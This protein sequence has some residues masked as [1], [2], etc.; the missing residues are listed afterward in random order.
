MELMDAIRNHPF[1][2]MHYLLTHGG[3]LKEK[4]DGK[5]AL[6]EAVEH[7]KKYLV[8]LF[9]TR[10]ADVDVCDENGNSPLH[11][12]CKNENS[13]ITNILLK[14]NA[15]IEKKNKYGH[16]P[17]HI[18]SYR[19]SYDLIDLLLDKGADLNCKDNHGHTPLHIATL[20]NWPS[21]KKLID[22]GANLDAMD[23]YKCTPKHYVF[24][25]ENF[26]LNED[27]KKYFANDF[28]KFSELELI[29]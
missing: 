2:T 20:G 26:L 4:I 21:M 29:S 10:G 13:A 23:N 15:D 6:I 22:R 19:G 14:K 28:E 24:L 25:S 7:N 5:Y 1:S 27:A 18:A 3:K 17:L 9:L 11:I 16:T 12:A 8:L